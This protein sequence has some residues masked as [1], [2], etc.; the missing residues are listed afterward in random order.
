MSIRVSER[1]SQW[2]LGHLL[3]NPSPVLAGTSACLEKEGAGCSG[4]T[5]LSRLELPAVNQE[6]WPEPIKAKQ[7]HICLILFL[8]HP[9]THFYQLL[10]L[11]LVQRSASLTGKEG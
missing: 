3:K 11:K 2:G 9:L 5:Y 8:H 1:V 6:I 4:L 7:L 10:V